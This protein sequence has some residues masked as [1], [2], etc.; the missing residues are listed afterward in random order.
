MLD[1]PPPLPGDAPPP[2]P[3]VAPPIPLP[4]EEEA[5]EQPAAVGKAPPAG[6]LFP[7]VNCGAKVA[8]DPATRSLSCTYCGHHE[9]VAGPGRDEEVV[10]RDFDEYLHKQE[11][12][13]VPGAGM[14]TQVRCTGCGAQVLVDENVVTDE[15]PFCGTHIENE[16]ETVAGMLPPESVIPFKLDLRDA[17]DAF[18]RWLT[19]LWF[20]PNA[21]KKLAN[22]GQLSGVYLP[23]WTYDAMTFTRYRGQRG[24]D[25]TVQESYTERDSNG[26]SVTKTRSVTHTRWSSVAGNVQHFFD[27]VLICGS[28][29]V[30][31]KL[32]DK[33]E[34]WELPMLEPFKGEFLSGFKTERYVVG[35]KEGF[36]R[37]K[38][39]M[40]P[41]IDGLIRRDIGGDRQRIDSKSTQYMGVTFKHCLLPVWVAHYRY[42]D[43]LFQILING[44]SGKVSGE[45][46]Y[47]W[48]KIAGWVAAALAVIVL[49]VVL[50]NGA[51][52]GNG[53]RKAD[54]PPPDSGR[55][56][57]SIYARRVSGVCEPERYRIL[58]HQAV[59]EIRN[60][61]TREGLRLPPIEHAVKSAPESAATLC[62]G[63]TSGTTV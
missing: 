34:P 37:A 9:T 39:K 38:S 57:T 20:A 27:D 26:N 42:F 47:S 46:P 4:H 16:P 23:Y 28:K 21:L 31:A 10:E 48:V 45:R 6:R 11:T 29:S 25:Y 51:K 58:P 36:S 52:K 62:M 1:V 41:T 53:K 13:A 44:R 63:T 8:F 15:C 56:V 24:D 30:P 55:V 59:V 40:E 19:T 49:I 50:V 22:L 60:T 2:L 3:G 35:L 32:V 5:V 43:K 54:V 7:C 61:T 12:N 14:Q 18:G 17:R 33:V